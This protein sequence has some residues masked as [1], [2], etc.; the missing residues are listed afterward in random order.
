MIAGVPMAV[1]AL[2]HPVQFNVLHA[3]PSSPYG[4]P[5][6]SYQNEDV[7]GL[8]P[9]FYPSLPYLETRQAH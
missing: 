2:C 6:M 5:A 9:A 7:E 1:F 3:A 8:Q 4:S